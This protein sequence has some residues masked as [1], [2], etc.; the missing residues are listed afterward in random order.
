[1]SSRRSLT[2]QFMGYRLKSL[3]YTITAIL[4]KVLNYYSR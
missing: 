3:K 4:I 1:M 2:K